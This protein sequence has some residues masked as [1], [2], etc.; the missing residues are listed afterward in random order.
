MT[1]SHLPRFFDSL[2]ITYSY[3]ENEARRDIHR[4]SYLE[5]IDGIDMDILFSK[6]DRYLNFYI[7]EQFYIYKLSN[8]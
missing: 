7:L 1:V 4:V 5:R 2:S 8:F 3:V 6:T